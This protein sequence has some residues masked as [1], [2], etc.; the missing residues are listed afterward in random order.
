MY[1]FAKI[2]HS[3]SL[4]KKPCDPAYGGRVMLG[5]ILHHNLTPHFTIFT[6]QYFWGPTL[7]LTRLL[8]ST[9][10]LGFLGIFAETREE[11]SLSPSS[12]WC[13]HVICLIQ[14]ANICVFYP[15]WTWDLYFC[16]CCSLSF[17]LCAAKTKHRYWYS[18]KSR[19][20]PY[21]SGNHSSNL[22]LFMV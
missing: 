9:I 11:F 15:H 14:D 1:D 10:S 17:S 12:H 7:V 8:F 6:T 22:D 2:M 13:L 4:R 5:S 16:L 18:I 20:L 21:S 3:R 19:S